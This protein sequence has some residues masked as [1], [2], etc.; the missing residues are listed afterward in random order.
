MGSSEPDLP[1]VAVIDDD[2]GVRAFVLAVL[3]RAGFRVWVDPGRPDAVERLA[4]AAPALLLLDQHVEGWAD[5]ALLTAVRAQPDLVE[6][7][8]LAFSGTY[9]SEDVVGAGDYVGFVPKPVEPDVLVQAVQTA[10]QAPG[11]PPP[12]DDDYLAPLRRQFRAGLPERLWRLEAAAAAG[13]A[14]ALLDEAHRLKGAAGGYGF[15]ELSA[16][17]RAVQDALRGGG[18][19]GEGVVGELLD[20]LRRT[21]G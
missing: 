2:P 9:A 6:L 18:G 20:L 11:A 14:A 1:L 5:G 19:V 12:D 8:V 7:P 4:A 17:A 21:I 13:D 10:L 16:A 3:R 15:D